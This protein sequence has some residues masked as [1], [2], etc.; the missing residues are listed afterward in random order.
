[1]IISTVYLCHKSTKPYH[2]QN[3]S[4]FSERVVFLI[5]QDVKKLTVVADLVVAEVAAGRGFAAEVQAGGQSGVSA[6]E[7]IGG[8]AVADHDHAAFVGDTE[9]AE[10]IIEVRA[11][12]LTRADLLRDIDAVYER[13][14]RAAAEAPRLGDGQ[15]VGGKVDLTIL[16]E[17]LDELIGAGQQK[18]PVREVVLIHRVHCVKVDFTCADLRKQTAKALGLEVL[19]AELSPLER[20]PTAQVDGAV[21]ADDLVGRLHRTPVTSG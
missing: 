4:F 18:R 11:V 7:H 16:T 15:T 8:Q 12:G 9:I 1:M 6:A 13:T 17:L 2:I 3:H 21:A 20:L 14:D 19:A 5:E 10:N